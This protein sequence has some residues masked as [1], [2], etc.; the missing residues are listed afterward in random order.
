M[1]WDN[2]A[3]LPV[4][5]YENWWTRQLDNKTRNIIRKAERNGLEIRQV[6]FSNTLVEGIWRIYNECP[7][8]QGRPFS[9]YGKDFQ[10]VRKEEATF[11]D[12]SIFIG[13]FLG[14]EMIGFIKL[15]EGDARTQASLINIVSMVRHRDKAP[16]NALI[17]GA[18]RCCEERSIPFLV[19]EKF[20]YGKKAPDGITMFKEANGFRRVDVPRYFV[21]FTPLGSLALR[22]HLHRPLA[23][24]IPT[25]MTET[26]RR[27][28]ANWY[29]RKLR[30]TAQP[31]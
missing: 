3:V 14:E 29:N 18:V 8:R 9:H 20:V 21:H 19:Y 25:R 27:F 15:V 28:R 26:L 5:T 12:S 23:D 6:P 7:V 24:Y 2:L 1:E 4:S 31:L 11:L 10:A 17:A 30:S 16:T 13:A 22:L